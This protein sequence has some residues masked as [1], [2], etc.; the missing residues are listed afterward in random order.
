MYFNF[1][2]FYLFFFLNGISNFPILVLR[3]LPVSPAVRNCTFP[4]LSNKITFLKDNKIQ[5]YIF[6]YITTVQSPGNPPD[7][8]EDNLK[9]RTQRSQRFKL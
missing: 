9:I 4:V 6:F 7:A 5:L 3:H 1:L 8:T 2:Y